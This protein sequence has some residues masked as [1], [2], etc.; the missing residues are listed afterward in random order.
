MKREIMKIYS[1]INKFKLNFK[2]FYRNKKQI[3]NIEL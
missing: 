3:S 2:H 1:Y